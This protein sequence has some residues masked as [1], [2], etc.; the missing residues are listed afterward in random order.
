LAPPIALTQPPDYFLGRDGTQ[1]TV[2]RGNSPVD[3]S[4]NAVV[5]SQIPGQVDLFLGRARDYA[6]PGSRSK[7]E[8]NRPPGT[9]TS[10]LALYN[11]DWLTDTLNYV[12]DVLK[13]PLEIVVS[14]GRAALIKNVYDPSVVSY[15]GA[16]GSFRVRRNWTSWHLG[17]YRTVGF[18]HIHESHTS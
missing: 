18:R 6:A 9:V 13:P 4:C 3:H 16:M 5:F 7:C 1:V 8:P 12:K 17:M 10:W 14:A 11:M 2:A 15:N